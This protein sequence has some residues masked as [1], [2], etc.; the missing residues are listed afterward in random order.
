MNDLLT[1][2]GWRWISHILQKDDDSIK[3][4]AFDMDTRKK[5]RMSKKNKE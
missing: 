2:R 3:K 4:I 5:M 1:T